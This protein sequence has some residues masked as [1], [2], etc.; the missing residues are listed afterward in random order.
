M[1]TAGVPVWTPRLVRTGGFFF[2]DGLTLGGELLGRSDRPTAVLC[3]NDLQ[4]LGV[5]EAARLAGLRIPDDVSVV[6]FDGVGVTNWC[7]PPM[8]TVRPTLPRDGGGGGQPAAHAHRR[9][10]AGAY[11]DRVA[12]HAGGAGQ[13]RASRLGL[14]RPPR[15]GRH[16][17]RPPAETIR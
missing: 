16:H 9:T 11:T 10:D 12:D 5:Y 17:R 8:T 3:G 13:H 6:G 1:E 14:S 15:V 4:A 7:G 2:E